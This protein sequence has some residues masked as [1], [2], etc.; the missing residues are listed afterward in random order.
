MTT[1]GIEPE[2][3]Y[4]DAP[5]SPSAM[6]P[7]VRSPSERVGPGPWQQSGTY[8]RRATGI[9]STPSSLLS[10]NTQTISGSVKVISE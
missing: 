9:W 6:L 7:A 1:R 5:G 2:E 4:R 8:T 10:L 3:N